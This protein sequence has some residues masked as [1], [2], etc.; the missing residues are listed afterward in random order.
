[1]KLDV[2]WEKG[3]P[4]KV[5]HYISL[6]NFKWH[7]QNG[8]GNTVLAFLY[9]GEIVKNSISALKSLFKYP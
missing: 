1:M 2:S 5:G 6:F 9:C 8:V 3:L 4:L 7:S